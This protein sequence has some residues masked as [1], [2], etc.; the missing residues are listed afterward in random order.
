MRSFYLFIWIVLLIGVLSSTRF[1]ISTQTNVISISK[2]TP[3]AIIEGIVAETI[4]FTFLTLIYLWIRRDNVYAQTYPLKWFLRAR[5]TIPFIWV[6]IPYGFSIAVDL[7]IFG[8]VPARYMQ[9]YINAIMLLFL[10]IVFVII[11]L[12]FV[13]IVYLLSPGRVGEL[14]TL[15]KK[16]KDRKGSVK[17]VNKEII[18]TLKQFDDYKGLTR[19]E[20]TFL[21]LFLFSIIKK[22]IRKDY[23][24][25]DVGAIEITITNLLIAMR[26]GDLNEKGVVK[27]FFKGLENIGTRSK[28]VKIPVSGLLLELMK[29]TNDKLGR[30]NDLR[31]ANQIQ[32]RWDAGL[33]AFVRRNT[34]QLLILFTVVGVGIAIANAVLSGIHF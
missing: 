22:T 27:D 21:F 20:S 8:D 28:E 12:L 34:N 10:F 5:I 24:R 11:N 17:G 2:G 32:G 25:F 1:T 31:D 6:V 19:P 14:I 33:L 30:I 26:Q 29:E 16:G 15:I 3:F 18:D 4:F 13:V 9:G 7:A 23:P